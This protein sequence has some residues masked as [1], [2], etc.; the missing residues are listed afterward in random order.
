MSLNVQVVLGCEA[1]SK[2]ISVYKKG[3]GINASTARYI[4]ERDYGW[5]VAKGK[6]RCF[7]HR[8]APLQFHDVDPVPDPREHG[9]CSCGVFDD[10]AKPYFAVH[11]QSLISMN[12][13]DLRADGYASFT[14]DS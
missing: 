8:T 3:A 2:T 12:A 7:D 10:A 14:Y 13:A 1:C 5:Q 4:A 11:R 9:R 6:E